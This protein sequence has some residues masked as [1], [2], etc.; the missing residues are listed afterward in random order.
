MAVCQFSHN[1]PDK[2]RAKIIAEENE[3]PQYPSQKLRLLSSFCYE[4]YLLGKHIHCSASLVEG[5]QYSDAD[6]YQT[7]PH[8]ISIPQCFG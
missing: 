6:L 3:H 1:R 8:E 7:D 4:F 5:H 2:K